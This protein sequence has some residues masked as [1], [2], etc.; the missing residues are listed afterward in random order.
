[1]AASVRLPVCHALTSPAAARAGLDECGMAP[2]GAVV[3]AVVG[4][5]VGG[6]TRGAVV[7]DVGV[8]VPV[9]RVVVELLRVGDDDVVFGAALVGAG[10]GTA[11]DAVV[12]DATV[13][14][15]RDVDVDRGAVVR[16][17][18]DFAL[19]LQPEASAAKATSANS[20]G[21]D[22]GIAHDCTHGRVRRLGIASAGVLV[23]PR[24]SRRRRARRPTARPVSSC[25]GRRSPS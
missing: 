25:S 5:T 14:L 9:V 16:P 12:E 7:R 4:A 23:D 13:E 17:E 18:P 3:G 6:A 8:V 20:A 22:G 19:S 2:V 11:E 21:R 1:M 15:T 24:R 10:A